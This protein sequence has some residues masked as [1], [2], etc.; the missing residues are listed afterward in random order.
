MTVSENASD[1]NVLLVD[2]NVD[3]QQ[4]FQVYAQKQRIQVS[5]ASTGRTALS[6]MARS[7]FDCILLDYMLPDL[8]GAEIFAALQR[9]EH[10]GVNRDTPVIV[11]SAVSIPRRKLKV[12]YAQGIK[13]FLPKS[14]GLR[15]LTIVVENLSF[16][17]QASLSEEKKTAN[18]VVG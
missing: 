3:F 9:E 8:N 6:A 1:Y 13:L 11:V 17:A 12:L 14:F 18:L 2:D 7:R 16:S 10:L 15:E 4:L 5:T